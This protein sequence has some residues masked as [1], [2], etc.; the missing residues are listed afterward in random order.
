[1]NAGETLGRVVQ[2]GRLKAEIR[3]PQ[4]RAGEV[5][6]G[7]EAVV[8][9]RSGVV[10]GRVSRVDPTVFGGTVT[11]DVSLPEDLPAGARPN[12]SVDGTIVLERL[13]DVTFVGRPANSR[14]NERVG[15]YRLEEDG[16][17]GAARERAARPRVRE[18]GR[19]PR[20]PRNPATA[21]CSRA[22]PAWDDYERVRIER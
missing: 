10:D 13:A 18:R 1:M 8:D 6:V 12:M 17:V 19:G 21:W 22:C 4:N 3:I 15:L 7:L 16:D 14:A 2:P 20:R 11:V 5:T 9:T